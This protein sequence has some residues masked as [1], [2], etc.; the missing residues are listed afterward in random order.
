MVKLQSRHGGHR[1]DPNER[2]KSQKS[3]DGI[4]RPAGCDHGRRS[5]SVKRWMKMGKSRKVAAAV[6]AAGAAD[7][8]ELAE[9][10]GFGEE[11]AA[12]EVDSDLRGKETA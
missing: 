4:E 12:E 7:V 2:L 11:D 9:A 6:V 5:E 8:E 10:F 3:M 1:R